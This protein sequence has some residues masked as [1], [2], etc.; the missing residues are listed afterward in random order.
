MERCIVIDERKK[1]GFSS[2]PQRLLS[3][4]FGRWYGI[5]TLTAIGSVPRH[6]SG[7]E[8]GLVGVSADTFRTLLH[9][10]SLEKSEVFNSL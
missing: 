8:A 9:V 5:M 7:G 10:A 1:P 3:E 2:Y 4:G 6:V